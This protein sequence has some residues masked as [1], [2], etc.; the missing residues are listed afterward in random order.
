MESLILDVRYGLRMLVA[1]PGFTVIAVLALALGIGANTAIFSVINGVLLKPLPY[2]QPDHLVRIWEKTDQFNQNSV[3]YPNFEDWRDQNRSF[4][5]IAAYNYEQFNLTGGQS[6]E[7]IDG[8]RVSY[9]FLSVLGVTPALGRDFLPDD[10]RLGAGSVAIISNQLWKGYF[11]A[12]PSMIGKSISLNDESYTVVGVLPADFHYYYDYGV[13]VTIGAKKEIWTNSRFMHP[14]IGVIARLNPNTTKAQGHS[15]LSAIAARLAEQYPDTNG[16]HSITSVPL[17]DDMVGDTRPLLL[18]LLA[19]VAAVLLIACANVAN[20]MLARATSRQKEIAVRCALGASRFRVARL[21][22]VESVLTSVLGGAIGLIVA[23]FGTRAAIKAFPDVLPRAEGIGIDARVLVFAFGAAILTGVVFG[24]APALISSRPDLNETLKEGGRSGTQGRQ[25][26]RGFLV[27]FE[28]AASLTLLVGTGLLIR[29]LVLLT[30]VNP[31]FDP[32]NVLS[33]NLSLSPVAYANPGKI[34]NFYKELL[35]KTNGIPGVTAASASALVPLD[36]DD[37]ETPFYVNGRPVPPINELPMAM[38]YITTPGYIDAMHVPLLEGRYFDDRDTEHS[39]PVTV[40]DENLASEYFLGEDPL[41][42]FI[43]VQGGKEISFQMQIVGVVGHVKQQNLDTPA[44]SS[45]KTQFYMDFT[46]LPDQFLSVVGAGMSLLV[47]T[48][49]DPLG[50][51]AAIREQL[52]E[53]DPNLPIA[54]AMPME[55]LVQSS[56]SQRWFILA[57]LGTFSALALALASIGIYGVISYSVAQRTREI[58]VRMALGAS[59]RQ[60]LAMVIGE[61]AKLAAVGIL[62]GGVAAGLVTRFGA[63]FLYGVSPTDPVTFAGISAIL[64]AV[65]LLAS[66]I[67]ARRAMKVDPNSALRYE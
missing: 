25:R 16:G 24:M 32:K 9:S 53:I 55:K 30:R 45:V 23:L 47:R 22:M 58:G 12:D 15:D 59:R 42:K 29:S 62:I 6:P 67:P 10:D 20:L 18:V 50:H 36:G 33:V 28:I 64:A 17:Y 43:T 38:T 21:L 7:R 65:A 40:I 39:Q 26:V 56:I 5:K 37:D 51:V 57:L 4:S 63:A 19:A 48:D 49:R 1:R 34:R 52:K 66:Y 11:G 2:P 8:R 3:A 31:G 27:A 13:Y 41:G 61:G 44:G 14:G 54:N 60:V 46:Q 35:Q